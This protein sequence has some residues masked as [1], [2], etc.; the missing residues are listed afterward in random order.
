MADLASLVRSSINR[1]FPSLVSRSEIIDQLPSPERNNP[2]E[3]V[4]GVHQCGKTSCLFLM[5]QKLVLGGFPAKRIFYFN[6]DDLRLFPIYND[7]VLQVIEE[8][9]RQV[10]LAREKGCYLFLDD[11]HVVPGWANVLQEIAENELVTLVVAGSSL[12]ISSD[13][14]LND[15]R[16]EPSP[17]NMENRDEGSEASD[18][19]G[20][21][22]TF[23]IRE[24]F[25]LSFREF[26]I[27][28]GQNLSEP[29]ESMSPQTRTRLERLFGRYLEEGG[30]PD[31][32]K[33]SRE[34]QI[35]KLQSIVRDIVAQEMTSRLGREDVGLAMQFALDGLRNSASSFSLNKT[36]ESFRRLGYKV[37]WEK[38]DK[39][40]SLLQDA[41]LLLRIDEH[42]ATTKTQS[43]SVP[44]V[45]SVDPGVIFAISQDDA[46]EVERRFETAIYLELRKQLV[47]LPSMRL[48]SYSVPKASKHKVDFFLADGDTG[49]PIGLIQA[50]S[51]LKSELKRQN[52]V[53]SLDAAMKVTGLR[54]GTIV[55][56]H[57]EETIHVEHGEIHVVPAWK[58]SLSPDV[59]AFDGCHTKE[60][61]TMSDEEVRE[62]RLKERYGADA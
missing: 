15:T 2:I 43:T 53:D 46:D 13:T 40:F 25:P 47:N 59:C 58:W 20:Q 35:E 45:Y 39:I 62:A 7:V 50:C 9:W 55:T 12:E 38:A 16:E 22:A 18:T 30:F 23:R 11:I 57:E 6:F 26:C 32:Q 8:Y 24:L 34:E 4:T 27:F 29:S 52:E 10:P 21:R 28:Q 41:S 61:I 14:S 60:P 1:A 3:V 56:M 54:E 19:N 44:K 51:S 42:A 31:V 5:M 48:T 33:R 36:V 49:K 17:S 37:Y